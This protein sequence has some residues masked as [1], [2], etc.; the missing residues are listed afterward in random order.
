MY[1]E[2]KRTM[3]RLPSDGT[4]H[5]Q[6]R[7]AASVRPCRNAEYSLAYAEINYPQ[8]NDLSQEQ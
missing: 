1:S 7:S 3:D 4:P 5:A 2:G 6:R 8:A